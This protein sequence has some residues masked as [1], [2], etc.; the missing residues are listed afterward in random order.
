MRSCVSVLGD[1]DYGLNSVKCDLSNDLRILCVCVCVCVFALYVEYIY[2]DI[3][4]DI[5]IYLSHQ[6]KYIQCVITVDL[7][8]WCE[9]CVCMLWWGWR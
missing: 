1:V 3:Y 2:Q 6:K 5:Y 9:L 8:R 7:T 4:R